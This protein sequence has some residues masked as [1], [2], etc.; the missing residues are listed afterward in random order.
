M[1]VLTIAWKDALL[2]FSE[3]SEL[4]FF[5]ILPVTFIFL[6]GGT[7]FSGGEEDI[8][9]L[10]S[11]EDH[12]SL[13]AGLLQSLAE[14]GEVVPVR[15]ERAAAQEQFEDED[16]AAWLVIPAGFES[17]VL[18][19]RPAG[20][21][22]HKQPN[23][24]EA[25]AAE[26]AASAA[27]RAAGRPVSAARL[28]VA[29]AERLRPFAGAAERET[30]FQSSLEQAARL[31][32]PPG[33]RM[34][35]TQ[36]PQPETGQGTG[37]NQGSQA[38]LGQ[39]VTW[40]FIPLVGAS[41]LLAYERRG[42][43]L[44]RLLTTPTSKAVYLLGMVVGQLAIALA[45]MALL[46]VFGVYVMDINLGSSPLALWLLLIVF[47]LASVAMGVGLGAFVHTEKQAS[48]LSIMIGMVFAL[49]G[50]CWFPLELFPPAMQTAVHILPTTWAMRALTDLSM[51]GL[52][53]E[54]VLPAVGVL[55]GFAVVFFV[56]GVMRF[57]Y[58]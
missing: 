47:G 1:R 58:E 23:S 44:L 34:Q 49:L 5:V 46:V 7:D 56:V 21:E 17:A 4:L 29:E 3:R 42:K 38:L 32:A 41:G 8:T 53:M 22:L 20:I 13:S 57:R 11:D 52:G 39:L 24:S 51:R 30:Y 36:P 26:Q 16:A 6:L 31:L 2:R 10:V 25:D 50:G 12:S 15:L 43:T 48:N 45:Q 27:A 33:G 40:V 9:L 14:R 28:A 35:A 18:E 37:Y 54:A 19:G 55:L